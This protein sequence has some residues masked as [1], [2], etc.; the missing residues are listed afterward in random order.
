MSGMPNGRCCCSA[1]RR[2]LLDQSLS[3]GSSRPME[4]PLSPINLLNLGCM[5]KTSKL[6]IGEAVAQGQSV[7]DEHRAF[8]ALAQAG[9]SGRQHNADPVRA[10]TGEACIQTAQRTRRGRLRLRPAAM[11]GISPTLANSVIPMAKALRVSAN[12]ASGMM[13]TL[14]QGHCRM[15]PSIRRSTHEK[16]AVAGTTVLRGNQKCERSPLLWMRATF[17]VGRCRTAVS[18]IAQAGVATGFVTQG[19]G[20]AHMVDITKIHR[21]HATEIQVGRFGDFS[22]IEL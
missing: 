9:V 5:G 8:A 1:R 15:A 11:V 14:A 22:D 10:E 12:R 19:V 3:S 6:R 16:N 18:V 4:K 21:A 17:L 13:S 20:F 7:T 2:P